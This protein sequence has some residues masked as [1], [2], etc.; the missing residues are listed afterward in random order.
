MPQSHPLYGWNLVIP[1]PDD[2]E[3]RSDSGNGKGNAP[4]ED[5]AP[6]VKELGDLPIRTTGESVIERQYV[7]HLV[8]CS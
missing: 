4:R 1:T 5:V 6:P 7:M 2:K 3:G 8:T